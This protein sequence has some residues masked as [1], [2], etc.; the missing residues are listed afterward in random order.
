MKTQSDV[1]KLLSKIG[2][3]VTRLD[4]GLIEVFAPG[5]HVS[6]HT[7]NEAYEE[8]ASCLGSLEKRALEIVH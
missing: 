2:G 6:G 1:L 3:F 4:G 7:W 5:I 8:L